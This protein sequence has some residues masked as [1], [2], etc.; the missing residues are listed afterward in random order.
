[1][2][3]ETSEQLYKMKHDTQFAEVDWVMLNEYLPEKLVEKLDE[4]RKTSFHRR[5]S[6]SPQT[7]VISI[8]TSEDRSKPTTSDI[9]LLEISTSTQSDTVTDVP[10]Y[11]RYDSSDEAWLTPILD[12]GTKTNV[13]EKNLR[14]EI[15]TRFLTAFA[16]DYE[17]Q[18]YIGM[19]RRPT[20][21]IL[22]ESIEKAKHHYSLKLHWDLIV[23]EFR[24]S[25]F[26]R[27]LVRYNSN[28]WINKQIDKLLFDHIFLTIELVLGNYLK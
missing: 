2:R 7:S 17:K 27:Y 21:Y 5:L 15:I 6:L 4:Q 9:E 8:S 1:M 20:L 12:V 3:K 11:N 19:I 16:V 23:E 10:T 13:A 26:L 24:L 22:V 25:W 28:E 18:W 14:N